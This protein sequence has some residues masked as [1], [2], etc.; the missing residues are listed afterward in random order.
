MRYE[1]LASEGYTE[2]LSSVSRKSD[3][4]DDAPEYVRATDTLECNLLYSLSLCT[5]VRSSR[6]K[7]MA[8]LRLIDA[9]YINR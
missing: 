7:L 8:A 3:T 9:M 2:I 5:S 6:E 4:N 1:S